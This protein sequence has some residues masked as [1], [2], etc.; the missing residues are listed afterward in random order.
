MARTARIADEP[1]PPRSAADFFPARKT[2]AALR[3]AAATCRGCDLYKDATQT[4]FGEGAA[5]APLMLVGEQPGDSED[6]E[7]HPFVGPAGK[8]LQRA[9]TEA[10][11]DADEVYITNAVKHFKFEWRGKRRIHAK[12]KRIEVRACEPWL[13]EEIKQVRPKLVVALGAT[14]AQALLGPQFRLTERRGELV[15]SPHAPRVVATVHP[16]SI[17]RAR[18]DDSR[19]AE[20]ARFVDDLRIVAAMLREA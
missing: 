14:A 13:I 8:L 12:P 17:L 15:A 9:M 16:S 7:G 4:V 18:D 3:K 19:H 20:M 6:R 11:I 5:K 2:L 1:V 10:G